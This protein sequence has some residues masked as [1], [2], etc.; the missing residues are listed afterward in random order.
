M[1]KKLGILGSIASIIGLVLYFV[2]GSSA[3]PAKE[4]GDKVANEGSGSQVVN[5]NRASLKD[6]P[7]INAP[8]GSV[9]VNPNLL[10]EVK[11]PKLSDIAG[12]W[13][14]SMAFLEDDEGNT[15][16]LSAVNITIDV[17]GALQG[18]GVL[19]EKMARG[20]GKKIMF[21][22]EIENPRVEKVDGYDFGIFN[23]RIAVGD[24]VPSTGR[25][26]LQGGMLITPDSP[27]GLKIVIGNYTGGLLLMK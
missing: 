4:G 16:F 21:S 23:Y 14:S 10:P 27:K 5:V 26:F 9:V 3:V 24:D 6:S 11:M 1:V 22:G 8:N 19:S 12:R 20:N 18:K 25:L 17:S 7:I 15:L 13:T 2:G